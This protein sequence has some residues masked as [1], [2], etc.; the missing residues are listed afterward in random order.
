MEEENRCKEPVINQ[1]QASVELP[2][3]FLW[4]FRSQKHPQHSWGSM[5]GHNWSEITENCDHSKFTKYR[6]LK[7]SKSPCE[8]S[9]IYVLWELRDTRSWGLIWLIA[10][11]RWGE[12]AELGLLLQ[13]P[14]RWVP[15][16]SWAQ[17]LPP[18]MDQGAVPRETGTSC[19]RDNKPGQLLL[20]LI[21]F[22]TLINL[23]KNKSQP[24]PAKMML[25]L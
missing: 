10:G 18:Y 5:E 23:W 12:N 16:A 15:K 21:H 8:L 22:C 20:T 11:N 25:Y 7:I 17:M 14:S 24:P 1:R 13:R 3:Y 19:L 6:Y 9:E 4:I 2:H